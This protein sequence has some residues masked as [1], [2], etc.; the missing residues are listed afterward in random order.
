M[1]LNHRLR[2]GLG[3][4]FTQNRPPYR[5]WL[6]RAGKIRNPHPKNDQKQRDKE[7]Y[8][9][10]EAAVFYKQV[11]C[12]KVSDPSLQYKLVGPETPILSCAPEQLPVKQ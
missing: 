12:V 6:V 5:L 10:K 3:L 9:A 8:E 11:H 4:C 1:G 7:E 2:Y